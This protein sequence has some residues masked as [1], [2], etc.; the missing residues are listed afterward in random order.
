MNVSLADVEKDCFT[1]QRSIA[2]SLEI[3]HVTCKQTQS[4]RFLY[5]SEF[6]RIYLD[7]L[8]KYMYQSD[9]SL[10]VGKPID[11]VLVT[12]DQLSIRHFEILY[13]L[14]TRNRFEKQYIFIT[15]QIMCR[16]PILLSL[17]WKYY[18][19]SRYWDAALRYP[20]N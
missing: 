15:Q 8:S 1:R 14:R 6:D 12:D 16:I 3:V 2:G 7:V 13:N 10:V 5:G 4:C 18:S 9:Q 17:I 19:R 11:K 20:A